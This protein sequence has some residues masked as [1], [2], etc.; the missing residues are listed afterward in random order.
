[1]KGGELSKLGN[2]PSPAPTKPSSTPINP[3]LKL[4]R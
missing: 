3:K 1:M 4:L 2:K